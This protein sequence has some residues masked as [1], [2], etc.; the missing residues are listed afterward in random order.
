MK[1]CRVYLLLVVTFALPSACTTQ[2]KDSPAP[3]LVRISDDIEPFFTRQNIT[4]IAKETRE[5]DAVVQYDGSLLTTVFL[6]PSGRPIVI[7]EQEGTHGKVSGRYADKIPF[8]LRLVMQV[9]SATLVLTPMVGELEGKQIHQSEI[10]PI[11]DFWDK[12]KIITRNI[13]RKDTIVRYEW[14][15]GK[16]CPSRISIVDSRRAY[17]FLIQT[18]QCG[19]GEE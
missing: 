12:G 8:D 16:T 13:V 10:G 6:D 9:I 5:L 19:E 4:I 1:R 7:L 14:K 15:E 2:K 17:Q 18:T 3:K 11:E